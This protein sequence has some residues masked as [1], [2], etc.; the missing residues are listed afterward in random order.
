MARW[1]YLRLPSDA[2]LW[3]GYKEDRP[4]GATGPCRSK[5]NGGRDE[6]MRFRKSSSRCEPCRSKGE[7]AH[8]GSQPCDGVGD[9]VGEA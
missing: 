1:I 8:D 5:L 9:G 2:Q 6:S 7:P 4:H 3:D